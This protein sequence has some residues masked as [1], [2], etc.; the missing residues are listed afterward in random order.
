[1]KSVF[2]F[3]EASYG[4]SQTSKLEIFRKNLAVYSGKQFP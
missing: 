4:T 3:L 1:M 2:L